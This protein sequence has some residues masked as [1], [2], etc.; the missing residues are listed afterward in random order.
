MIEKRFFFLVDVGV[1][2]F[3]KCFVYIVN[4]W[5]V[6]LINF[7]GQYFCI[8]DNCSYVVSLLFIG[9]I[10]CGKILCFFYGVCFDIRI[11]E[12]LGLFVM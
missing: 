12:Y 5:D 7:D 4:G 10:W 6:V 2:E 9:W 3:G 11:G 8:E 1:F